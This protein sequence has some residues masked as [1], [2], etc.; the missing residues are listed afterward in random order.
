[1]N[2][3]E[4]VL[5][6]LEYIEQAVKNTAQEET[7][8]VTPDFSDGNV[9]VTP[10]KGKLLSEVTIN[11]DSNL[12]PEN[13]KDGVDVHGITGTLV[14][15]KETKEVTPDFSNGNVVVTP[16]NGKL[17]SKVTIN[18]DGNLTPE[19]IKDGVDIHGIT[20]TLAV[21][22]AG[23]RPGYIYQWHHGFFGGIIQINSIDVP[24]GA[25][26][27]S[28]FSTGNTS[29]YIKTGTTS[30]E[31]RARVYRVNLQTYR[32]EVLKDSTDKEIFIS[33]FDLTPSNMQD[34]CFCIV[35]EQA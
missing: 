25:T 34:K 13:I 30:G 21:G 11:K 26:P 12:T 14:A 15:E 3:F 35:L 22:D 23:L 9:V 10:S 28:D 19:N 20:G 18:K 24:S 5:S 1:M 29:L 2:Q 16:S 8:E 27:A 33:Y 17:L 6:K 31:F 4:R 32:I 7:K